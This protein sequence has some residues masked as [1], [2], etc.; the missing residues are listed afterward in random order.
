[1]SEVFDNESQAQL[2]SRLYMLRCD[3]NAVVRQR[4]L[5]VW[6]SVVDHTPATLR[7]NFPLNLF[8][9]KPN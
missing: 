4:A 9:P 7:S 5:L 1:M 3:P 6:K 2:L 8:Q